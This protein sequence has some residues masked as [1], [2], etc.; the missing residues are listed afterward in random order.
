MDDGNRIHQKGTEKIKTKR[1]IV[2]RSD[3]THSSTFN[4]VTET[5]LNLYYVEKQITYLNV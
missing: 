3:F 1:I 5:S 2:K 4:A